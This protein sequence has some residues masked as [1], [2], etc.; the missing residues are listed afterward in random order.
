MITERFSWLLYVQLAILAYL[1][2][3]TLI[4]PYL[5]LVI[6]SLVLIYLGSVQS[7]KVF[8]SNVLNK[9][10]EKIDTMSQRDVTLFPIYA[11]TALTGLFYL[12]KVFDKDTINLLFHYYFCFAG[13]FAA[14]GTLY[15]KV[16]DLPI[17]HGLAKKN[18]FTIPAVPYV[19]DKAASVNLLDIICWS[20]GAALT[21]PYFLEKSWIFNNVLGFSFCIFGIEN[22][23]LGKF[24]YGFGLLI[25]LFFYDIFFVFFTPIMVS[26]A[27]NLDGPI[28]FMFPK[29]L[30]A[31]VQ[32]DFNMLGLGDI[33]IPGI[34]VALMLRF[35]VVKAYKNKGV[36]R[37]W[38]IFYAT[39]FGYFLGIIATLVVMVVFNHA[40]PALLYL[41][42]GVLISSV[43]CALVKGE[44]T[45]LWNFD[46]EKEIEEITKEGKTE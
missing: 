33:V 15:T 31:L 2:S 4:D 34:Y 43:L 35:D 29:V 1:T 5:T 32:K 23:F 40:Q 41:V 36:H 3:I 42:P 39:L 18:L 7:L 27:K 30:P 16:I 19:I 28:K 26:V 20:V 44:L 8:S 38:S 9:N 6:Y 17:L 46:E 12:F 45:E 25:A 11:G 14:G 10:E 22:L 13:V 21:A 37:S 24:I